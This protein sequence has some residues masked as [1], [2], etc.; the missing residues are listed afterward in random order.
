MRHRL[1]DPEDI[2]IQITLLI[3]GAFINLAIICAMTL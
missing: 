3:I 1:D 2:S